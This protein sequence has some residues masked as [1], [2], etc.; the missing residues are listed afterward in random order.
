MIGKYN[1]EVLTQPNLIL[2][3]VEIGQSSTT[4]IE[5]PSTGI[6]QITKPMENL[7]TIFVNKNNKWEFVTNLPSDKQIDNI[8]LLPGEYQIVLRAKQSTEIKQTK[9]K[10]FKIESGETTILL[11]DNKKTK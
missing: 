11:L 1:L 2:K 3:D 9:V 8:L 7:A 6:V 4:T 5:I 10:E